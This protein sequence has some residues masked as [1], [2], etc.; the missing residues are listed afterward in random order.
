MSYPEGLFYSS[1]YITKDLEK[2][3]IEWL[4]RDDGI[5]WSDKLSRRTQHFGGE[6]DYSKK[7]LILSDDIPDIDGPLLDV[8]K[9]ISKPKK[10]KFNQC[11]VNEYTRNQG[12]AAHIDSLDFGEEIV[13]ISLGDDTVMEFTNGSASYSILLEK[14]SCMM[15]TKDARYKWK[16]GIDK[17]VSYI[18][19]DEKIIKSQS[20]RRIS[21]TFR[22]VF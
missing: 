1:N 4:D 5:H 18:N 14:R 15:M 9:L 22:I 16:H 10:G 19:D 2:K 3:I 11:I 21:L 7:K 12:I 8:I 20:Y 17:K 6:Y 13:G